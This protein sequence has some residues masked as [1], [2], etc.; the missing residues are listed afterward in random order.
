MLWVEANFLGF[1]LSIFLKVG[2][3][4]F[5]LF[6]IGE[7]VLCFFEKNFHELIGKSVN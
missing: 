2:C 7:E 5:F 4:G 6:V 3:L 1:M